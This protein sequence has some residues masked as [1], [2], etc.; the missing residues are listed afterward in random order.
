[1]PE[2]TNP[3]MNPGDDDPARRVPGELPSELQSL[4]ARLAALAPRN[5]RLDRER[6]VFLAGQASADVANQRPVSLFGLNLPASVWPRAFAAMT[7]IAAALFIML[8]TRTS[9]TDVSSPV[10]FDKVAGGFRPLESRS[11]L[12]RDSGDGRPGVLSAGD[13]RGGDVEQLLARRAEDYAATTPVDDRD[14]PVLT[15][16]AWRQVIGGTESPSGPAGES[17]SLPLDR[18]VNS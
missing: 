9:V 7:A 16:A 3:S 5:D 15:P 12:S 18:G 1:M 11:R 2:R 17:S 14:R 10:P 6:L 4:E 8:L 13:A